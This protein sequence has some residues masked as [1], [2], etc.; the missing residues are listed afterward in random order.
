MLRW[1]LPCLILGRNDLI[2]V[3]VQ[4]GHPF[5]AQNG[6]NPSVV[7]IYIWF[8]LPPDEILD[9]SRLPSKSRNGPDR[10]GL[11]SVKP[12]HPLKSHNNIL[13]LTRCTRHARRS[14]S[15][16]SSSL[17]IAGPHEEIAFVLVVDF[18][19]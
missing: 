6:K 1:I 17:S 12:E 3:P 14:S 9:A 15:S 18:F 2:L 7:V 8:P 19:S 4:G 11:V 5:Y 16:S 10:I 13:P